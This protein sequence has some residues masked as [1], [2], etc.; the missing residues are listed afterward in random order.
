ME[1]RSFRDSST[2]VEQRAYDGGTGGARR[3]TGVAP[4][5]GRT[6]EPEIMSPPDP[7]VLEKRRRRKFTAKYKLRILAEAEA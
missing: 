2:M 6:E 7:E 5:F 3:A 4:S 1:V